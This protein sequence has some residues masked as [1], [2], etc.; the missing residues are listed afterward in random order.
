MSLLYAQNTNTKYGHV[1]LQ[2]YNLFVGQTLDVPCGCRD[3]TLSGSQLAST[4]F[5]SV[6][7]SFISI[8]VAGIGSVWWMLGFGCDPL[9]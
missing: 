7:K 4:D 8:V 6:E 5:V 9:L 3:Y 2:F 1:M